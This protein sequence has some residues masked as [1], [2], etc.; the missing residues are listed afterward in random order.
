MKE[1]YVM[2]F[3]YT[4]I[5]TALS[6]VFGKNALHMFQHNRYEVKRYS[7]WLFNKNNLH[8]TPLFIYFGLELIVFLVHYFNI[9]SKDLY[10]L[11]VSL[12]ITIGYT[13][14]YVRKEAKKE[15]IKDLVITKRVG[16]Q[17]IVYTIL[18]ILA[19]FTFLW[20]LEWFYFA[21]IFSV[22]VPYLLIYPMAL[23]TYPIEELIKKMYEKDARRKLEE[24]SDL[25][26]IGVT[27]SF[28]K[29]ST[30]NIINDIISD[31]VY[32][33]ITPSS[34]NTPMGITR[35]IREQLKPIHEVFVCEMGADKKG[36]ITY[37]M[38]FVKPQFGVVTSIGPQHLATFKN[39]DNIINEKM[40][41]IELLPSNGVG[42]V[43]LDNEYIA[44]YH[45]KNTCK[46]V[47]VG[48]N[49]PKA[50]L[51]AKD[52][53]YTSEG[54]SFSVKI[55]SKNYKF[56]TCLLGKHNITNILIGIGVALELGISIEEITKNV[57]NIRQIEHRLEVKKIH[58]FT[59]IDDAFNANPVGSKMA[60]DVLQ[61]MGGRRIV[62]TPGM[63]DLG[64]SQDK[65]N[66]EFGQYMSDKVDFVLLVGE[67]QTK[68]ICHGLKDSG[69]NMH[70]VRIF[71]NVRD[72]MHYAYKRFSHSDTILIENDLPDAFNV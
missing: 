49:N 69:F 61:L 1:H 26:I 11:F 22:Y 47:S 64:S 3:F 33:Q 54:S 4:V 55:G 13:V 50:D 12:G 30:K 25:K 2:A 40:Q 18:L 5:F 43:N 72:A 29:T 15:Y 28:G 37:L 17:I 20:L 34:F 71:D 53:K 16:R 58:D 27:G 41:E 70:N 65:V 63:I 62:V 68:P 45:I 8:Y 6:Y 14:Y 52:I 38:N 67:K 36:D 44:N 66:Y 39:I 31:S 56:N 51:V 19:T 60:I 9:F 23:I 35:T 59:I 7:K 48:I 21:G 42:F 57:A 10:V 46:I 24:L 32:T